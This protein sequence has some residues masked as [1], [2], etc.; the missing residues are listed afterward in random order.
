M[1]GVGGA[2]VPFADSRAQSQRL[3]VVELN[4]QKFFVEI[5]RTPAEWQKGLMHR[6]HLGEREGMLFVGE[7]EQQQSF[8]MKNTTIPLDILFLD[9]QWKVVHI[10]ENTT[11]LS[12]EPIPSQQPAAHVLELRGGTAQKFGLKR[13]Q[14]LQVPERV[15]ALVQQ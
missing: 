9:S 8:W 11:P 10:A 1:L 14:S 2:C 12:E 13:G 3:Q 4:S 6:Q 7:R 15:R 5:A